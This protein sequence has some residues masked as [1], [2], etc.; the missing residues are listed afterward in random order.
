MEKKKI[1]FI[2]NPISGT[3][4][5][6]KI[7]VQI[8]KIIDPNRFE[9]YI[10]ETQYAGHGYEL[11]RQAV[12]ENFDYVVAV[13]GDGTLNE[14]GRALIHTQTAMGIIPLGSGNG[15]ARDLHIS[16]NV[17]KAL[18]I[19]N[20]EHI[21]NMDY[22]K[23][24]NRIFFCT[25]GVGFDANVAHS[26]AGKKNRGFN[27]YLQEMLKNYFNS[28]PE[29]YEIIYSDGSI[30]KEL[31]LVTCANTGQYG[32]GAYIAPNASV[33]DGLLAVAM[34]QPIKLY[35]IPK[36]AMQMFSRNID[37]NKKMK[38]ILVPNITIR[39]KKEGPMH[40]D[41][42]SYI[43]G[44]NIDVKIIPKGIKVLVPSNT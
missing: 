1:C 43:E 37:R 24:N 44:T 32:F 30:K 26:I 17:E 22:G 15:L 12:E 42:D 28:N 20:D 39:R 14:V 31:F 33:Q 41:G 34:L 16:T 11:S 4:N 6:K 5:K 9:I 3:R 19:I 40:L 2:I 38:E 7:P 36:I 25:C 29:E 18:A 35:N 21:I 27:M 13:G 10:H 8:K 23:A